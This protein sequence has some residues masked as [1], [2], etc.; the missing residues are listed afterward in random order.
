MSKVLIVGGGAAGMFA[1]IFAARNGN[2]VHVF[3]KNEKLGKKSYSLPGKD[4]VILQ[5]PG[6]WK[7][8]LKTL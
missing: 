8:C 1:S 4:A 3:E 7:I 2:E 5:M 6:I